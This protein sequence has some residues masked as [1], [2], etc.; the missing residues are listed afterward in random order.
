MAWMR[1]WSGCVAVLALVL[2][3]GCGDDEGPAATKVMLD[4]HR[5]LG[6]PLTAENLTV[7]P[8]YTDQPLD[9]GEF[10]TL[11]EAQEKGV[12][13]VRELGPA[14]QAQEGPAQRGAVRQEQGEGQP[15]NELQQS[16]AGGDAA[17]VGTL[18]I[19]NEGDV[20]ILV[21]AGTVVKGGKQDRQIGQDFVI[22]AKATVPVDAFCVEQG[23]WAAQEI[24]LVPSNF[25]P[26]R[27]ENTFYAATTNASKGVRTSGQ[28]EKNQGKVWDEVAKNL[29][30]CSV[31]NETQTLQAALEQVDPELAKRRE[32]I[33]K[34]VAEHFTKL[35]ANETKPV[36]FAYAIN[37]KPVTVRAFAHERLLKGQLPAFLKAMGMEAEMAREE[38]A[39]KAHAKDVVALVAAINKSREE[40][41]KTRAANQN[42]YRE[43]QEGFS[44]WCYIRVPSKSPA[45]QSWAVVSADWTAR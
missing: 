29:D 21:C 8:V 35:A 31:E 26:P 20:P 11:Q 36:G 34:A 38:K 25:T 6:A 16:D 44:A 33:E 1:R 45:K 10:L 14:N 4:E 37:G 32:T 3:G 17:Q 30:A 7:W 40:V 15:Q 13:A 42:G 5:Y 12:A 28:Y 39:A 22:Q 24:N 27:S 18:V 43:A 9:L 23:R 2:V 41:K 19:E